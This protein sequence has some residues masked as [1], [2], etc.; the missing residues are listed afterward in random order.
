[1]LLGGKLG[2]QSTPRIRLLNN[3]LHKSKQVPTCIYNA[4]RAESVSRTDVQR[5]LQRLSERDQKL[6]ELF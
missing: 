1:M 4:L 5:S 2:S 3:A 6:P